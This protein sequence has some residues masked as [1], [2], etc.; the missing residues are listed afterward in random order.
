VWGG[1]PPE[2]GVQPQVE[3][4]PAGWVL[5][6]IAGHPG[7]VLVIGA[8]HGS[9]VRRAARC[10]VV[11][12]RV[13]RARCPVVLVPPPQLAGGLGRSWITWRLRHRILTPAQVLADHRPTGR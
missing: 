5:V 11:R 1:S 8:G 13:A 4:G 7:D 10:R 3:R 12:Y 2:P 9:P 6:S